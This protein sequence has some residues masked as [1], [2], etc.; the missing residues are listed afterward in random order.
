MGS[1]DKAQAAIGQLRFNGANREVASYW[2]SLWDNDRPPALERFRL[3]RVPQH[4]PAIMTC[5]VLRRKELRCIQAGSYL[6]MALG[7][8]PVDRDLLT[9][10]PEVQREERLAWCWQI[11]EGAMAVQY[12]TFKSSDG[13]LVEAQGISLPFLD[14]AADGARF[15]LMHTNWRPQGNDWIEGNVRANVEH[16]ERALMSF[17]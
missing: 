8:D 10:L 3:D 5:R 6:P 1:Y 14:V 16:A 9:L 12:R 17:L 4:K 11:A 7:F 13:R 15:F 2:L